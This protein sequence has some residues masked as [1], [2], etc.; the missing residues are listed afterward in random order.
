MP[1]ISRWSRSRAPSRP[2]WSN[3]RRSARSASRRSSRSATRSTSISA[4]C[5]TIFAL[6]R[7]TRAILLYV[8]SINDARKFMSAAR[9]AARVKPVVVIKSGRHAQGARAAATHTGAL[10]GSDAVYD[11]AFRRAGLLRVLDLDELFAAAETLGRMKPFAGKRLAILTNGGGIGVLAVDRLIDLG[12]TLAEHFAETRCAQLDALLPPIWSRANPGRH[13]RRRR[14]G[15]L[16]GGARGAARRS[17]E[18]RGPGD[19]RADRARLGRRSRADRSPTSRK[20]TAQRRIRP[21]PVFAVWLGEDAAVMP[22]PSSGAAFRTFA[23]EADAVAGFMHLV[24]YREAQEAL[25][26]TP[27]SLPVDFQPDVAARARRRRRRALARRAGAGS[28]RSKSTRCSRPMRSRSRRSLLAR[29]ADEAAAAGVR[30]CWRRGDGRRQDPLARHRAQVRSRRRAAQ[31]HQRAGG[32]RGDRRHP[33]A[34]QAAEPDARITGVT[35]HPMVVRPKARE[36]IAGTRRRSDLRSGHRVRPRRHRGRGHRRQGAGAAAARSRARARADRAHARRA[37]AQGLPRRAR[38]RTT[39][40]VALVLVKLAQLAADLPEVRELDLNPLLADEN[41]VIAVDARVAIAPSTRAARR[42]RPSAL[43][44]P[45]LSEGMGAARH[46][47]RRHARS[48]C[49]RSG[50]RT[51]RCTRPSS[52]A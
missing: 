37:R 16:R 47:A 1:A 8:E 13:R 14:R 52:P 40:A 27:P 48:S 19:E 33:G 7:G 26:A 3:G 28:I 2:A 46:A 12:G 30:R 42:A 6:D 41:G 35:L 17:G 44:D 34:R 15:A 38:R 21:K 32:A 29:D 23:T 43:C 39:T 25:M 9:A 10:A 36:L 51:S 31:P 45:A 20:R 5:S 11:A 49:G 4:I 50:R 24:R 22:T 18:R